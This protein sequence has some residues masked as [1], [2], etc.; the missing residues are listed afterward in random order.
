MRVTLA[1]DPDTN[2]VFFGVDGALAIVT[3]PEAVGQHV[4]ARLKTFQGEWFLDSEVGV[5]W[6]DEIFAR[7]Y[8]A[9]LAEAVTK[10]TILDTDGV[11][12]IETFSV[13][14]DR[15]TRG[16]LLRQITVRTDYDKPNRVTLYG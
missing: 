12:G 2:D 6:L 5:P 16:L 1:I 7:E 15:Q 8:N 10:A 14:F 13:G 11:I 3:G 9:A 4:R